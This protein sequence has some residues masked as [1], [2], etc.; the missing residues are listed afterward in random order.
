MKDAAM[1]LVN[2]GA[3]GRPLRGENYQYPNSQMKAA[4]PYSDD[5]YKMIYSMQLGNN[6][7][8]GQFEVVKIIMLKLDHEERLKEVFRKAFAKTVGAGSA[9]AAK[10]MKETKRY[11][12]KFD[13][14]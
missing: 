7:S 14:Y 1:A 13:L 8:K 2:I 9:R 4:G 5:E 6:S 12:D 10:A 11:F 3:D